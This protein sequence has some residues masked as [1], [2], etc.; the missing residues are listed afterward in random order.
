MADNGKANELTSESNTTWLLLKPNSD[1][2]QMNAKINKVIDKEVVI[3]DKKYFLFPLKDKY[4][5]NY[6]NGKKSSLGSII[7]VMSFSTI[8]ILILLIACFNFMNLAIALTAKRYGEAGIKKTL[9]SARKNII[10]QFLGES[11]ILSLLSFC[12]ALLIVAWVLPAFNNFSPSKR[13]LTIPFSNPTVMFAFTGLAIVAGLLAGLYPAIL[14]SSVSAI[15]I[16]KRN[17]SPKGKLSYFRQGLIVFQFII[18]VFFITFTFIFLKQAKYIHTMDLGLTKENILVFENHENI[19]N[20]QA[21]FKSELL[22]IP[23]VSSVCFSNSMPFV[24]VNGSA[25]VDWPGRIPTI[26]NN[27]PL[28][29][30]DYGFLKTL[31]PKL[32]RGRF[33]EEGLKTDEDNFVVNETAAEVIKQANP[34][35]QVITVNGRKGTII[36]VVKN[37][38]TNHLFNPYFP[39]II[40]INPQETYFTVIRFLPGNNKTLLEKLKKKYKQFE[41]DYPFEP[42]LAD[43]LFYRQNFK[44]EAAVLVG[45]FAAIA[46]FLACLGLF[47]LAAFSAEKRTKEIGVRKINGAS[48]YSVI[49]LLLR[50]YAKWVTI[51]ICIGV[52]ISFLLGKAFLGSFAFHTSLP[53]WAFAVGPLIVICIALLT[54]SLLTFKAAMRNPVESLRYE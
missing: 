15:N 12:F 9:G 2:Q 3:K 46:I 8:A 16:L 43:D 51:A 22:S 37:F 14:L 34:V 53:L 18:S 6:V 13:I 35:G 20:H 32:L 5:Y 7:D 48:I 1:V 39:V 42:D 33:F 4:L 11:I 10:F 26:D 36:G 50:A 28:I 49:L 19:S 38:Q 24:N 44:S 52:P 47:G 31:Q 30:T 27:F 23:E 40:K 29:N 21:T 41:S 54:V 45:I 17:L 25:N